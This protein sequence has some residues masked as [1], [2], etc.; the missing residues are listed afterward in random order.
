MRNALRIGF[1][2][3]LHTT[4]YLWLL[5]KVIFPRFGHRGSRITVAVL[6][7]ISLVLITGMVRRNSTKRK[8]KRFTERD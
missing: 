1:I 5:P 2:G 8:T 4:C 7:V 6:V 3:T